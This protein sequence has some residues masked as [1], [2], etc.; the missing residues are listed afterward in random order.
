[1]LELPKDLR[2]GLQQRVLPD[3]RAPFCEA[4]VEACPGGLSVFAG[5]PAEGENITSAKQ[6]QGIREMGAG[7][8]STKPRELDSNKSRGERRSP[9]LLNGYNL[10]RNEAGIRWVKAK[11]RNFLGPHSP[12]F[13]CWQADLVEWLEAWQP[14]ALIVEANPRYL[15]TRRAVK[16]MHARGRPVVGWGLG[17]PAQAGLFGLLRRWERL[18]FLRSLDGWIAYSRRGAEQ[19]RSLG[20]PP[21]H[22][23]TACNAV[24]RRP[25]ALPPERTE[26]YS[27]QPV[28]LFVGRMQERKRIDLLLYACAA[29]PPQEQPRLVVVGDGPARAGWQA[30]AQHIYPQAEFPGAKRG[31]ELEPYFAAADLFVLPGSG[32]LAVQQAMAAGLPVIVAQGDGT[33]EDLVRLGSGWQVRPDDL[34]DLTHTLQAALSDPARLR[35]MGQ[36]SYRI[37]R[38]EVNLENMVEVFVEAV[39]SSLPAGSR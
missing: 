14:D 17:A 31:S 9:T 37:V 6:I 8:E 5:M 27:H 20:L 39:G 34:A 19:Y 28:V 24:A 25:V 18:P 11:N 16:W 12:F 29:L 26:S 4:L 30:L 15:S 36:E 33:Q 7:E 3:Y 32:G 35:R 2:L 22:I 13:L 1:M 10:I 38:D 23:F 21:D